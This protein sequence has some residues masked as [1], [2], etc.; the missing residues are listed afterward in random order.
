MAAARWQQ[1]AAAAARRCQRTG[2]ETVP[3]HAAARAAAADLHHLAGAGEC[4]YGRQPRVSWPVRGR[5]PQGQRHPHQR[6]TG[7]R[8]QTAVLAVIR[9]L[10][11][12][13]QPGG[14]AERGAWRRR[15]GR[16]DPDR[17]NRSLGTGRGLSWMV[18][19]PVERPRPGWSCHPAGRRT[20]RHRGLVQLPG[21]IRPRQSS[22][23]APLPYPVHELPA[24]GIR[25]AIPGLPVQQPDGSA[26]ARSAHGPVLRR[27]S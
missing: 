17:G 15:G 11:G 25:A 16:P 6:G 20:A 2:G 1:A 4:G 3:E 9:R 7:P 26:D 10:P 27:L 21:A 8:G 12:L 14:W 13:C 5:W 23:S 22:L 18:R 19:Q 24:P